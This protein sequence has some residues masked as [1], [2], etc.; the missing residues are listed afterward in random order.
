MARPIFILVVIVVGISFL[1][2]PAVQNFCRRLLSSSEQIA[3]PVG[4]AESPGE[5]DLS[6]KLVT[7]LGFDAILAILEPVFVAPDEAEQW[8]EPSE[9]VLGV[10]INGESRAYPVS[11][12]SRHEIVND[13]LGG[14]PIAV[15]W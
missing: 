8:M 7:L 15:T 4:P 12:L 14:V 10:T 13:V 11:M 9:D 2:V 3:V 1:T 5:D 6:L